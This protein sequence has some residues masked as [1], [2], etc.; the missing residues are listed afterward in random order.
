MQTPSAAD[1]VERVVAPDT[2][3]PFITAKPMTTM[4]PVQPR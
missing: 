1:N 3:D 2:R 4:R